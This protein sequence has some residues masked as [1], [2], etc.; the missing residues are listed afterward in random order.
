MPFLATN[1]VIAALRDRLSALRLADA[2][3]AP[4]F[5]RVGVFGAGGLTAAVQATFASEARVCFIV[6]GPEEH[7]NRLSE[8][9]VYSQRQT[10]LVLL[11]ADRAL[12]TEREDAVTG[13]PRNPGI[14]ALK[15][16]VIDDLFANPFTV[17]GLA[18]APARG[19]PLMI[20]AQSRSSGNLGREVWQQSLTAYA[21]NHRQ[22][23]P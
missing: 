17:A 9:L 6:P 11:I 12:D 22:A 4:L 19:E 18:F 15:D 2:G 16:A 8:S 7:S 5:E 23:I 13:G 10:T 14:L 20:E 1:A 3:D 21:G